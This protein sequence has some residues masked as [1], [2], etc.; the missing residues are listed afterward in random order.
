MLPTWL[1]SDTHY[2]HAW[3]RERDGMDQEQLEQAWLSQI[4]P[5]DTVLHLGDAGDISDKLAWRLTGQ[6]WMVRGNHDDEAS[7]ETM[8]NRGWHVCNPFIVR[9]RG[10]RLLFSHEPQEVGAGTINIHGHSHEAVEKDARHINCTPDN[11][12]F[13]PVNL[14][15]LIDKRI[16][17]LEVQR[18]ERRDRAQKARASDSPEDV[19]A[20]N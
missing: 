10:T 13:G 16:D 2:E 14:R 6:A 17:L 11:I 19:L 8:R 18:A 1:I 5:Q 7:I 3:R 15:Q 20:I 4:G 9:Y 12:G